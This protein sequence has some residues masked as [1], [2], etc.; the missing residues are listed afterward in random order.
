MPLGRQA[1]CRRIAG[2]SSL[3]AAAA[4]APTIK[5][6]VFN[7]VL[8]RL[9]DSRHAGNSLFMIAVSLVVRAFIGVLA[10]MRAMIR[11][12]EDLVEK[13]AEAM[14]LRLI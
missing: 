9:P 6:A 4:A 13:N 1:N 8:E 3:F 10:P 7:S 14:F 5:L 12:L 2:K 11:M